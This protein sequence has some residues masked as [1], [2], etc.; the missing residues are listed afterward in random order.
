MPTLSP[1]PIHC[2]R[3]SLCVRA[4]VCVTGGFPPKEPA[5]QNIDAFVAENL[6]KWSKWI[7][8][9]NYLRFSLK[10]Q[11]FIPSIITKRPII[12]LENFCFMEKT[13]KHTKEM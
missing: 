1:L 11:S 8:V 10:P 7:C 2:E 9:A 5:V 6:C 3:G 13:N 4:C 12:Y